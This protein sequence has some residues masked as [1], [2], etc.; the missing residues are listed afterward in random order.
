MKKIRD[1]LIEAGTKH[2]AEAIFVLLSTLLVSAALGLKTVLS[3]RLLPGLSKEVLAGISVGSISLLLLAMAWVVYLRKKIKTCASKMAEMT[4]E[5]AGR[6]ANR[7]I[8]HFG[9]LWSKD[10]APHCP[11]CSVPLGAFTNFYANIWGFRCAKCD[12][13]HQLRDDEGKEV[14]FA[15]AKESLSKLD[16]WRA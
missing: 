15:M 3:E 9:I 2:I 6:I 13:I 14:K 12:Q 10:L 11:A 5:M 8:Y 7:L 4:R 16:L 1:M